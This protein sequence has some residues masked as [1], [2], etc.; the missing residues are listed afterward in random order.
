MDDD[1]DDGAVGTRRKMEDDSHTRSPVQYDS[2]KSKR[3][4]RSQT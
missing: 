4:K 3:A 1:D 2:A